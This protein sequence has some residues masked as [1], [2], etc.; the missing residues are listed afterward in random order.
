MS[1]ILIGLNHRT[2][3][4]S[5][6]ERTTI[7]SAHLLKALHGLSECENISGAVAL[8]TCHRTEIYAS[9]TA[10][11]GAAKTVKEFLSDFTFVSEE[12]LNSHLYSF[13]D[14]DVVSHLFCV[15]AGLDSAVLGEYEIQGQVKRAWKIAEEE[16]VSDS[17]LNNLFHRALE[18]GKRIR[19]EAP[20]MK[21]TQSVSDAAVSMAV[22]KLGTLKGAKAVVL[23]SGEMGQRLTTLLTR[24]AAKNISIANRTYKNAATMAKQHGCEAIHLD[25][26]GK[27]LADADV[28]FSSTGATTLLVERDEMER[29]MIARNHKPLLA[30]DI[31]VPRD[32]DPLS[33]DLEG[34]TLIDIDDVRRY[35]SD[36]HVDS[37]EDMDRAQEILNQEVTR[38]EENVQTTKLAPF[39]SEFRRQICEIS[40]DEFERYGGRLKS[41]EPA[42][43]ETVEELVHS[44]INKV[45]HNPSVA[46]QKVDEKT[47]NELAQAL[48]ELFKF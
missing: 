8:S 15:V 41:L 32:I 20:M 14:T 22:E 21:S 30:V 46:I 44:I 48:K 39:I 25:E 2:A 18:T 42:E 5:L 9:A 38:Y 37:E 31:A 35:V 10:F 1:V 45:L 36:T 12:E 43:R 27:A 23:G 47:A 34:L 3:P 17:A 6:L 26:I 11:H 33:R 29:A 4:L 16:K 40:Q 19:T 7:S 28:L 24:A 13:T